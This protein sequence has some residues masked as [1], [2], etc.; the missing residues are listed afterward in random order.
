MEEDDDAIKQK[1]FLATDSIYN[2]N[3]RLF[4]DIS[5]ILFWAY[6]YKTQMI[7]PACISVQPLSYI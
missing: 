7:F 2:S 5:A 3:C 1:N 6:Q 4:L